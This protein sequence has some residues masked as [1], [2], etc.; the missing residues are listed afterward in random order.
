M[1]AT[2]E[3]P[4][5]VAFIKYWGRKD[6]ELRL[7]TNGSISMN[8][9]GL[10][11]KT[12]VFFDDSLERDSIIINDEKEEGEG[13]QK[14]IKHLDR[15]RN[16][17]GITER[18]KV[19][20]K[21]TFPRSTGL[22]SSASGF[23]ALTLAATSAAGLELSEKELSILARQG[24]GSACRSI[25][26]GYVEWLDGDSS[27][28]SYAVSLFPPEHWDLVDVVCILSTK[29]KVVPTSI[30]QLSSNS[31]P[32]FVKRLEEMPEKIERMKRFIASR[33]FT[34]FGQLLEQEAVDLHRIMETSIP[35]L[36]YMTPETKQMIENVRRWR[37]E[38]LD[39]YFTVNTGENIHLLCEL[40]D[41]EGLLRLLKENAPGLQT[42]VNLPSR[43]ARLIS[44]D[45]F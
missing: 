29:K 3:A 38:G 31:S 43:G 17:A 37:T 13:Y 35:P 12:T 15:V 28:S 5:N 9:D 27:D 19:I 18:A 36:Y 42:I 45:L 23:A 33:D 26:D 20:S 11:T 41:K 32:Y 21:N 34:A 40:K 4:S 7:P 25:P 22:S 14:I 30:G 24:S 39:V 44:V 16:L 10:K 1:K 8:L 6:E 2:A